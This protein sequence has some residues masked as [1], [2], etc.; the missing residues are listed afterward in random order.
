MAYHYNPMVQ[1]PYQQANV[2]GYIITTTSTSAPT[3][4]GYAW[5]T[6]SG[7]VGIPS[8]GIPI[9]PTQDD[10]KTVRIGDFVELEIVED[11][12]VVKWKLNKQHKLDPRVEA[13]LEKALDDVGFI[14]FKDVIL[15]KVYRT[16]DDIIDDTIIDATK[17]FLMN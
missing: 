3:S 1:Y 14:V 8:V 12:A 2:S 16:L 7:G 17:C 11:K 5:I 6:A 10:Y 13:A 9:I 15:T 4:S